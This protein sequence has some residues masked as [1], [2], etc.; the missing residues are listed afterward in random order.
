MKQPEGFEIGDKDYICKVNKS[1][2]GLKQ[3]SRQWNKRFDKLI[4][5]VGFECSKYETCVY[6]KFLVK[7]RFIE[8]LMPFKFKVELNRNLLCR[9]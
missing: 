7:D 4:A 3:S 2:Y 1:L 6:F 8:F 9:I 5:N